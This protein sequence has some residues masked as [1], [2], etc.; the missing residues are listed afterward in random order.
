ML[1]AVLFDIMSLVAGVLG[2]LFV[3]VEHH[4]AIGPF[5]STFFH[6]ATTLEYGAALVKCLVYGLV[7]GITACYKGM[8]VSGGPEGV[9][10]AVN[11]TVVVAFLT[12]GGI[13]Y[14]FTQF[15]LA[16]FPALSQVRG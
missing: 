5:F 7:I 16:T 6:N 8:N 14:F 10:R 9:G 2:A 11:Q 12:I 3:V 4:A 1:G 13:D 15:L